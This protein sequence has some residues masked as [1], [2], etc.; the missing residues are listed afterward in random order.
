MKKLIIALGCISA[1]SHASANPPEV[2]AVPTCASNV[3]ISSVSAGNLDSLQWS[4]DVMDAY[5]K[6]TSLKSKYSL[7]DPMGKIL[8]Q[9]VSTA[10]SNHSVIDLK[11]C[12]T[13]ESG[14]RTIKVYSETYR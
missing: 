7:G 3:R 11:N 14:F 9:T 1:I 4:L 12:D 5:G 10:M 6:T 2:A 13:P 8:H